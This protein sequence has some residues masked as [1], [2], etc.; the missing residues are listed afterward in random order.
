MELA[1]PYKE[2]LFLFELLIPYS[3][4]LYFRSL[5]I[6]ILYQHWNNITILKNSR[7]H[8]TKSPNNVR[9][10]FSSFSIFPFHIF[11]EEPFFKKRYIITP[12][13]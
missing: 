8:S 2:V 4:S 11:D 6:D 13:E 7:D 5:N 3:I 12:L 10:R 1:L 9:T